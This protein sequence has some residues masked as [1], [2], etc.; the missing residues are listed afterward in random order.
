MAGSDSSPLVR[1]LVIFYL[2]ALVA[3]AH[4]GGII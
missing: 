3:W 2:L 4:L 1:P